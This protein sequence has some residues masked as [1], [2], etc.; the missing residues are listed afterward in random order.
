[1]SEV[2]LK[3]LSWNLHGLAWPLS[4][5]PRGRMDRVCAKVRELAPDIVLL[6]EVWLGSYVER[7]SGALRP[8][9]T[10]GCVRRRGGGPKGG[11][12]T[13]I[14]ATEGWAALCAPEFHAFAA[15]APVWRFWEGD[16]LGGKGVLTVELGRGEQRINVV[17]THLQSQYSGYPYSEVREAQLGELAKVVSQLHPL[18]PAIAAGDLNTDAREP[19]YSH[20]AALG[21]DLTAEA[22]RLSNSGTTANPRDGRPEWIDYVV[23]ANLGA[24]T[25]S[26]DLELIANHTADVPYSDHSGLFCVIRLKLK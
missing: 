23:A 25:V 6:Q 22:R 12:L 16:G 21:T 9:W 15:S 4:K 8:D 1:M 26:I 2:Q 24:W 18:V 13:F 14:G 19:L 20:I 7:L 10:P 5:D 3:V 17:N 11:L